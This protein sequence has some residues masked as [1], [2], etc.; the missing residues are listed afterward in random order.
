MGQE[1][2]AGLQLETLYRLDPAGDI[3]GTRE[4]IATQGPAL[5]L[6]RDRTSVVV[7][8]AP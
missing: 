8:V 6:I 7:G 3:V 1:A 4:P 2:T 5:A